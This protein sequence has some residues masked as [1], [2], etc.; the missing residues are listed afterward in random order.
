MEGYLY[1][2]RCKNGTFY[3]GSTVNIDKR[4]QEHQAGVG[5]NYTRRHRP[6]KLVYLQHYPC[7]ATAFHIEQQLHKWSH[8]KKQ[9]LIEGNFEILR[10]LSHKSERT[11]AADPST[12]SG[13]A[14]NREQ[15]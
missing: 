14:E 6:V 15:K 13:I 2:L 9:A 5:A 8:S 12:S 3:V 4:L 1:I 11:T 10:A 7:I